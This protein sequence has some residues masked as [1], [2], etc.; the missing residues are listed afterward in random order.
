RR[1]H[2]MTLRDWSSDVCSSDLGNTVSTTPG[3]VVSSAFNI[4][5]GPAAKLAFTTQ[6]GNGT[7]GTAF[8]TQ[9]AV[10]LQDAGGNTVTGTAQNRSEERRVGKECGGP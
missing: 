10:T 3:V 4:T 9:P 6:P 7:G 2:T 1:R 8:T 5:V